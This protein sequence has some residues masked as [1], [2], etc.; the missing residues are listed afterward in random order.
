MVA[1]EGREATFQCV[2]SPEDAAVTWYRDGA[3]LQPGEKVLIS[4]SG[5][6][7]SLTISCLALEDAGQISAK[8]EGASTSAALR[9]RGEQEAPAY[10]ALPGLAESGVVLASACPC[11]AGADDLMVLGGLE[12]LG[13]FVVDSRW[14][15]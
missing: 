14:P 8:A 10:G 4:R 9:V 2:V 15:W 3:E 6:G 12:G 1:E 13:S 11:P 7:H 5:A